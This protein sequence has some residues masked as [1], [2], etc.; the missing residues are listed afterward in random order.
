MAIVGN[1]TFTFP[2][3]TS[4]TWIHLNQTVTA[5][6]QSFTYLNGQLQNA[7][8]SGAH[9][10]FF[11]LK[12]QRAKHRLVSQRTPTCGRRRASGHKSCDGRLNYAMSQDGV[13]CCCPCH[14]TPDPTIGFET[15]EDT[16]RDKAIAERIKAFELWEEHR[17]IIDWLVGVGLDSRRKHAVELQ[18]ILKWRENGSLAMLED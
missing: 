11:P 16:L 7:A 9:S 15:L 3:N 4:T 8:T 5:T 14:P 12:R 17:K 6:N 10:T 18:K 2:S 13:W 1:Y